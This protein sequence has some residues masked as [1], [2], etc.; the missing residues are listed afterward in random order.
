MWERTELLQLNSKF[1]AFTSPGP[2]SPL[3]HS[4]KLLEPFNSNK[5]GLCQLLKQWQ[6][7]DSLSPAL[8]LW[9]FNFKPSHSC[10]MNLT[11]KI[12]STS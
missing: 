2:M 4:P 10:T 12:N 7:I 11:D 8:L 1:Q 9:S 5:L 3:L 6:V